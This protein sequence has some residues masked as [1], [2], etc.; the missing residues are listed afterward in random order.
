M[1]R[2]RSMKT[3]VICILDRSGSM[4]HLVDDTIGG[5][6]SFIEQ[7]KDTEEEILVT[8]VLFNHEYKQVFWRVPIINVPKL[9]REVYTIGGATALNDAV[10]K[11][12][13]QPNENLEDGI[14]H[15][16][17]IITDGYENSSKEYTTEMIKR[18]V[19][20]R[21]E[22][23]W[24]F[25]FLGANIDSFAVGSQ[26][27]ITYIDSYGANSRGTSQV[28]QT[29][30]YVTDSVSK[31]GVINEDWNKNLTNEDS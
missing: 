1:E 26:Y 15:L 19:E 10:G 5:Y 2:I 20:S 16:V 21:K 14:K 6:N 30:S 29:L 22:K 17:F 12:I 4:G 9:T 28:Y 8:L 23:G 25:V 11:A 27:G 13:N 7:Q 31:S 18:L 3:S 24:E